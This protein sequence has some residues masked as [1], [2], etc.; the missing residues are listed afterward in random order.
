MY[1][2]EAPKQT[3]KSPMREIRTRGSASLLLPTNVGGIGNES[4]RGF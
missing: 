3:L 1:T 2:D 4:Y